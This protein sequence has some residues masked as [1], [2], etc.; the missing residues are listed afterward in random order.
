MNEQ[1][2]GEPHLFYNCEQYPDDDTQIQLIRNEDARYGV[3]IR[4][5]FTKLYFLSCYELLEI[6]KF[7]QANRDW[8][9]QHEQLN[10]EQS[11]NHIHGI[12]YVRLQHQNNPDS[13]VVISLFKEDSYAFYGTPVQAGKKDCLEYKKSDWVE[14][15]ERSQI[16]E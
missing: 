6:E 14:V 15:G 9:V 11:N 4:S 12:V 7:I 5:G 2:Y 3:S 8:I 16:G 13:E 10:S 1:T